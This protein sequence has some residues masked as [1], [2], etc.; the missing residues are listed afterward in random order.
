MPPPVTGTTFLRTID[1]FQQLPEAELRKISRLL[2][3]RRVGA[4]HV[5]FRQDGRA[6]SFYIIA[7]GRVKIS[8]TDRTGHERVLAFLGAGEFFGE[9]AIL[10]GALWPVTAT[11]STDATVLRLSKEHLDR[12]LA[13]SADM[14]R[15]VLQV[16]A[17]RRGAAEQRLIQE[18]SAAADGARGLV[19]VAFSPRGGSGTTTIAVN[20]AIALAQQTPDRVA[21]VDLSLPFGHAAVLLDVSPRTSLAATPPSALRQ[22]DGDSLDRFLTTHGQSSLKILTGV[23][24]PEDGELLTSEHVRALVEVLKKN[25]VHVV[26]D[27]ARGFADANLAAVELADAVLLVCTPERRAVDALRECQRIFADVLGLPRERLAYV[28]NRPSPYEGLSAGDVE[29]ALGV[30]LAGE[31]PF[32]GEV[33]ARAALE[34][35]AAVMKWPGNAASKAIV[36]LAAQRD[37]ALQ[38]ARALAAP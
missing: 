25:F 37:R 1:L 17:Q 2:K 6:D 36:G 27:A 21:L 32:G 4:G 29:R 35:Q 3:V 33:P 18:A 10:G 38:E 15:K 7:Q 28:L 31:V 30:R 26:V 24:R 19:T 8:T 11:A 5:L 22:F 14:M 23:L 34:G 16:I 9:T 13:G 20:L 12:L